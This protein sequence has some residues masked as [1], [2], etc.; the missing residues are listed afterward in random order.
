MRQGVKFHRIGLIRICHI[1]LNLQTKPH[2]STDLPYHEVHTAPAIPH[3]YGF[4]IVVHIT[5]VINYY[6]TV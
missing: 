6:E 1:L 5:R 2:S 3:T 4:I